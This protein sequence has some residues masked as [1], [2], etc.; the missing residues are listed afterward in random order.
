MAIVWTVASLYEQMVLYK[1]SNIKELHF[2]QVWFMYFSLEALNLNARRTLAIFFGKQA[3]LSILRRNKD[4]A[5]SIK[6]TPSIK[7]DTVIQSIAT[8]QTHAQD[9]QHEFNDHANCKDSNKIS[10]NI[11]GVAQNV[12]NEVLIN[13]QYNQ[14]SSSSLSDD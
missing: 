6:F 13:R 9:D 2:I 7:W 8:G 10:I 3:I 11:G 14:E 5:V 1:D 4:K 12:D